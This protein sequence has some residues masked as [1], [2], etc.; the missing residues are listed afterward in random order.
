[1]RLVSKLWGRKIVKPHRHN[2]AK[3]QVT[4]GTILA[5]ERLFAD[6]SL[7]KMLVDVDNRIRA[8]DQED[9]GFGQACDDFEIDWQVFRGISDY[10]NPRKHKLWQEF[11]ALSAA[12]A[13]AS[14]LK[15]TYRAPSDVE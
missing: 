4:R 9:S 10:G 2:A 7:K 8:G 14:F 13:L 6:G 1:M 12:A 3:A 11:A 15:H 5:G